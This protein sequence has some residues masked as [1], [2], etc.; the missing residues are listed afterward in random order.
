MCVRACVYVSVL[1]DYCIIVN[2][3]IVNIRRTYIVQF[4]HR[5]IHTYKYPRQPE[6]HFCPQKTEIEILYNFD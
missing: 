4:T 2:V 3:I 1:I 5:T 6:E